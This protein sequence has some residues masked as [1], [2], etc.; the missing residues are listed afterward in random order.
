MSP[1]RFPSALRQTASWLNWF[2][3]SDGRKVPLRVDTGKAAF[4]AV[5]GP[6]SSGLATYETAAAK[7]PLLGFDITAPFIG[8]DLDKVVTDSG[9]LT[10]R[11]QELINQLPS[12]YMEFSP[13][14]GG[15]HFWYTVR[16][17]HDRLPN[18]TFGD[19]FEAYSRN[20]WF[21]MTG[22]PAGRC[23]RVTAL[24]F[25]QAQAVFAIGDQRTLAKKSR[26]RKKEYEEGIWSLPA[27]DR[28]LFEMEVEYR[29][30]AR[31]AHASTSVQGAQERHRGNSS[32][33]R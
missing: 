25:K 11:G 19:S 27:L 2:K 18:A 12:T 6:R 22:V 28:C 14:G 23:T 17:D 8:V 29:R 15:L 5:D 30:I 10:K 33:R 3:T 26:T 4:K 32:A 1:A 9:K 16:T 13:S 24:S 20:R 31:T 21:T 7:R